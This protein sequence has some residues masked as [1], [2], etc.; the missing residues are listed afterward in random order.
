[1]AV[2]NVT[3]SVFMRMGFHDRG[4]WSKGVNGVD[5]LCKCQISSVKLCVYLCSCHRSICA[6]NCKIAAGLLNSSRI[7]VKTGKSCSRFG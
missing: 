4:V 1:M 3:G 7:Q 6:K 2:A 5:G